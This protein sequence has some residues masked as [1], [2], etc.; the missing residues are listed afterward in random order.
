MDK[1]ILNN[2]RFY[3][4]HGVLH[5][6]KLLGQEFIINVVL[7][8]DL[9]EAGNDDDINKTVNYAEIYE[10]IQEIV[11]K[12]KYNLIEALAM[13]IIKKIFENFKLIEKIKI[14]IDKPKAPIQGIFGYFGIELE[15]HR[16]IE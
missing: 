14:R 3:G 13:S 12:E 16:W 5:E 1:I 9:K 11:T 6:E 8:L 7:Y 4:Y 2:L 15:R 10:I